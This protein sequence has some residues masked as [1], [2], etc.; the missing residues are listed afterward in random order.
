[1]P[2]KMTLRKRGFSLSNIPVRRLNPRAKVTRVSSASRL[3]DQELV[4]QAF[5]Q[6]L[7]EQDIESFKEILRG[8]LEAV[9]KGQLAKKSKT[10]RR[11]LHRILSPQGNPTLKNISNLIHALYG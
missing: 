3:K 8:H 11:T 2:R 4:F 6:C 7:V 5:W 9:N 1:M 10:S